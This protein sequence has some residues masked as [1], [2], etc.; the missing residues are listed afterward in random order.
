MIPDFTRDLGQSGT[1]SAKKSSMFYEISREVFF[2]RLKEPLNFKIIGLNSEKYCKGPK[3]LK[4]THVVFYEDE[5]D[6]LVT[7]HGLEKTDNILFFSFQSGDQ[8]PRI[9]AEYL[10][11]RGFST[12]YFFRGHPGDAQ[13]EF[14]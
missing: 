8:D 9:A 14:L 1:S 6:S 3:T 4:Y 11:E 2:Q 7:E 12:V 10:H 5:V 13:L